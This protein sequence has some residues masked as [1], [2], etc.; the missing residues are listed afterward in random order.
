MNIA[1]T[2]ILIIL[3]ILGFTLI[4][5][6]FFLIAQQD[7]LK[8]IKPENRTIQPNEVWL[9]LIP[10]FNLYWQFIVVDRISDSIRNEIVERH[11]V[12]F[13]ATSNSAFPIYTDE[14]PTYNLGRA[15][16]ILGLI[17]VLG[18]FILFPLFFAGFAATICWILYWV[19]IAEHKN[20]F[21]RNSF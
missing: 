10:L 15:Y 2:E 8:A 17:G 19:Q 21:V 6:I 1:L 9:Q 7:V 13:G 18:F 3:P 20:R 11:P 14:R 4:P 5:M 12:S 16:C